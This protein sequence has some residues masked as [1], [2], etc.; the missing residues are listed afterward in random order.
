MIRRMKDFFAESKTAVPV[1]V[2]CSAKNCSLGG[3]VR[4]G[5]PF[6]VALLQ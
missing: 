1:R 3:G 4:H 5:T 6:T 2:P